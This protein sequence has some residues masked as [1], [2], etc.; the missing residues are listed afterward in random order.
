MNYLLIVDDSPVDAHL[1]RSVLEKTIHEHIKF[2]ENGW[3]A[4]EQIENQLPLLVITDLNMP[5]IDGLQLTE[6]IH[7]RFPSVP[8]I[9]MT[10]HGS[11][12]I[13][14]EALDRGAVDFVPK[15][16]LASELPH[17]VESV[18]AMSCSGPRDQLLNDCL[19]CEELQ[20][21]LH[22]DV[23]LIPPLVSRLR[24][25]ARHVQLVG[26]TQALRLSKAISE[27]IR[28]A[29]FLGNLE[30]TPDE[31]AAV[32]HAPATAEIVQQRLQDP[33]YSQRRTRVTSRIS[34]LV[35]E[36]TIRDEGPGFDTSCLPNITLNPSQLASNERRGLV[37][38]Q[39]FTDEVRFNASG[40]EVVLVK[41]R[42]APT[43]PA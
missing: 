32:R 27:A 2:A 8:V 33:H 38:I 16:M 34:S 14:A 18:L 25:T 28:N 10:A 42:E 31:W 20:F 12:E 4:L 13:A 43:N 40:N 35:A 23:A 17:A 37:L 11:E 36:F 41:R 30:L 21:E 7:Q 1:A 29:M 24:T 3:F 26:E 19:R 39:A 22:N 5:T 6:R 15:S 9:L